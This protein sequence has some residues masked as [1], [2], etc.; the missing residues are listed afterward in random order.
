[1]RNKSCADCFYFDKCTEREMCEDYDPVTEEGIDAC[2]ED[3]KGQAYVEYLT[4]WNRYIED[5]DN[6]F[7]KKSN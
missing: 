2:I 5:E 1:M 3:M 7:L 6:F 4:L